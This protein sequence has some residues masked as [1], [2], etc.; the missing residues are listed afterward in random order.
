MS[1]TVIQFIFSSILFAGLVWAAAV[2]IR[3]ALV[4]QRHS[5]LEQLVDTRGERIKDLESQIVRLEHRLALIEGQMA[6]I[7]AIKA[8]EIAT[9]VARLLKDPHHPVWDSPGP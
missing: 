5:E 4:K 7:Q 3:S 6:A 1:T 9:E 2:Y 8:E